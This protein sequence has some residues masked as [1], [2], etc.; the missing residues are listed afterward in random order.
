MKLGAIVW[1]PQD[2][3]DLALLVK[4][5]QQRELSKIGIAKGRTL[6]MIP[7]VSYGDREYKHTKDDVSMVLAAN[8]QSRAWGSDD[9]RDFIPLF[10]DANYSHVLMIQ[11]PFF[12]ADMESFELEELNRA[13]ALIDWIEAMSARDSIHFCATINNEISDIS[14]WDPSPLLVNTNAN[15]EFMLYNRPLANVSLDSIR[16]VDFQSYHLHAMPPEW[17]YELKEDLW[18]CIV[19]YS[20]SLDDCP[21]SSVE[22]LLGAATGV[23]HV[24]GA[25]EH[26]VKNIK[27]E[28]SA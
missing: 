14:E 11:S 1:G 23:T 8:G 28:M 27:A 6:W 17:L 24:A 13:D 15:H 16:A 9:P 21:A 10:K 7:G 3:P 22:I 26:V 19:S 2:D 25:L 18:K 12:I 20:S 5:W 4:G